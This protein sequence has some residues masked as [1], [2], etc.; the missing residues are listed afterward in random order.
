[1]TFV[2]MVPGFQGVAADYQ[3]ALCLFGNVGFA[4]WTRTDHYL[5]RYG[6]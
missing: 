5:Q 2:R 3:D 4:F 6:K 1:M